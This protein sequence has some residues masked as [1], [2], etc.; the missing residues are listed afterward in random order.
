MSMLN[1]K[2]VME[3]IQRTNDQRCKMAFTLINVMKQATQSSLALR[4]AVAAAVL[5]MMET[6]MIEE[7]NELIGILNE[8][9]DSVC[10]EAKDEHGIDD[11]RYQLLKKV[12]SAK[13]II[14][15]KINREKNG[16]E[17][18]SQLNLNDLNLN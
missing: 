8:G 10:K 3:R 13:S 15:E 5:E 4:S 14:D 2:E 12:K 9:I 17:I 6:S 7:D 1:L 11:Y 18:L 16:D